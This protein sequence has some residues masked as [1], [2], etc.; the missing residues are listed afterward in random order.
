MMI[1]YLI[2]NYSLCNVSNSFMVDIIFN[3]ITKLQF[4]F[5]KKI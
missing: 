5:V 3:T 4:S 2:N 1:S